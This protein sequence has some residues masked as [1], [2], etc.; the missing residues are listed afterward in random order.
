MNKKL[1][2]AAFF[3]LFLCSVGVY[4]W[5]QPKKADKAYS[6]A[7]N[8]TIVLAAQ[9]QQ[10][11]R[12]YYIKVV[13][14]HAPTGK[15]SYKA[16]ETVYAGNDKGQ[17]RL[18]TQVFH[19]TDGHLVEHIV[20]VYD[21]AART[22]TEYRPLLGRKSTY[23]LNQAQQD[24]S[25]VNKLDPAK[26]C[27]ASIG[28][29]DPTVGI[30]KSE[31]GETI[32]LNGTTPGP[33]IRTFKIIGPEDGQTGWRAPDF[34]CIEIKRISVYS[35]KIP[36]TVTLSLLEFNS[37]AQPSAL[38][39]QPEAQEASPLEIFDE[40]MRIRGLDQIAEGQHQ[41]KMIRPAIK[42]MN[43]TYLAGWKQ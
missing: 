20:K 6:V 33:G 21:P 34:G 10:T 35:D 3:A 27:N 37:N 23:R 11:P 42:R 31:V 41:I 4:S 32:F 39:L 2:T 8:R 18:E 24:A 7:R 25:Y 40:Q 1:V 29:G 28:G 30:A 38:F 15:A 12:N 16:T 43:D 13:E 17:T 22:A 36:S 14:T 19:D 5:A 9:V 26:S